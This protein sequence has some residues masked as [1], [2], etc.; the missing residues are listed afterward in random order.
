[1]QHIH[2]IVTSLNF[3]TIEIKTINSL[4]SWDGGVIVMVTCVIKNKEII[5]GVFLFKFIVTLLCIEV[6]LIVNDELWIVNFEFLIFHFWFSFFFCAGFGL[7]ELIYGK[8]LLLCVTFRSELWSN[9]DAVDWLISLRFC[10][11]LNHRVWRWSGPVRTFSWVH[12]N[13]NDL[14]WILLEEKGEFLWFF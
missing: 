4:D 13:S 14:C 10:R 3:S 12:L 1:M 5:F 6:I 2:I 11:I 8:W 7:V 9:L